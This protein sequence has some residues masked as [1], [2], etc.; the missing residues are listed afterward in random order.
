MSYSF[1]PAH[2]LSIKSAG[3]ISA[4]R[5]VTATGAQAGA[6][7]NTFGV[8]LA[9]AAG[10][11]EQVPV[12]VL[13]TATVEAGAAISAGAT[14]K[15]DASGRAIPWATAGAKVGIALEAAAGAGE[16]IEVFLVPNAA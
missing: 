15:S 8:S 9:S 6:D 14:V 5:F 12:I 13:G 11:G 7:A 16:M 2:I 3:A 10:A 4:H 1:R